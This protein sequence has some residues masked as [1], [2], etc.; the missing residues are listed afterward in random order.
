MEG[1]KLIQR[2]SICIP[3]SSDVSMQFLD[4]FLDMQLVAIF[5]SSAPNLC[6]GVLIVNE[7][8]MDKERISNRKFMDGDNAVLVGTIV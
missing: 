4:I 3:Q 2:D 1:Q 5:N 7:Q 8:Y 6:I